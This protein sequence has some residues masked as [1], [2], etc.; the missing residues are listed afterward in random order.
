MKTVVLSSFLPAQRALPVAPLSLSPTAERRR[1]GRNRLA[2][3]VLLTL[4]LAACSDEQP[5]A[6][7]ATAPATAPAATPDTPAAEATP[8]APTETVEQ[9]SERADDAVVEQRLFIPAGDNAFELYLKVLEAKPDHTNARNAIIDLYPYAVMHVE[10]RLGAND[11]AD[12]ARVLALMEKANPQAPALPRLH[13]ALAESQGRATATA[14]AEA[15][16]LERAAQQAQSASTTPSETTTAPA[17]AP[18]PAPVA[19]TPTPT[20]APVATTTA[21]PPAAATQPPRAATPPPPAPAPVRATGLPAVTNQVNPRYPPLALRRRVEGYV[22]VSFTVL[23][24]GTVANVAVVSSEPRSMFDREAV[25]AMQRWRFAP[26]GQESRGRRTFDF[27]L[28]DE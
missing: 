3:A 21:P 15:A 11:A 13:T 5:A 10:Q 27:K 20:P 18:T 8:P 23:P 16:R 6:P 4:G 14:A 28:S 26:S 22:E 7:T 17:P 2:L 1:P 12:A 19:T 25:N 24:D 9:L